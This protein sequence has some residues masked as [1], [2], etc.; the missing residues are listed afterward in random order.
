MK[1]VMS[2]SE[3]RQML[4]EKYSL[5]EGVE[6]DISGEGK[7][8]REIEE[9]IAEIFSLI[10]GNNK[11]AAIKLYRQVASCGLK[12]AKDVIENWNNAIIAIRKLDAWVIPQYGDA[13]DSWNK[14]TGVFLRA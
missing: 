2:Y 9:K 6:I 7:A 10:A 5:P 12:E 1:V 4:I 13:G 14:V 3:V 8:C 11:I